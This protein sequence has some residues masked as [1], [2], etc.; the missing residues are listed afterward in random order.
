MNCA[1]LKCEFNICGYCNIKK[2]M[3]EI[4]HIDRYGNMCCAIRKIKK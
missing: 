1:V 3:D 2:P 4:V